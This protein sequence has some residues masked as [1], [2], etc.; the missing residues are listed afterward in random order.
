MKALLG[1]VVGW[2]NL[3]VVGVKGCL[4]AWLGF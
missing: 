4:L 2:G 1:L 3:G